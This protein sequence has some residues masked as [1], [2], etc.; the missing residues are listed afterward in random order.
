[1][2]DLQ[3]VGSLEIEDDRGFRR[4]D[5]VFQRVGILAIAAL[6][7]AALAGLFGSGPLADASAESGGLSVRYE[8]FCRREAPS[9]LVIRTGAEAQ[10]D[11]AVLTI[12]AV[13]PD[14]FRVEH[15][16]PRPERVTAEPGGARY[17][18]RVA[19]TSPVEIRVWLAPV[20]WG[21][22]T[23][24]IEKPDGARVEARQWVHF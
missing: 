2:T 14:A 16:T 12:A 10:S 24:R 23:I 5:Q 9:E 3:R 8:R 22:S 20:R 4:R 18:F 13:P 15:I 7:A 1:M 19:P 21:R 11:L 6:M 17:V